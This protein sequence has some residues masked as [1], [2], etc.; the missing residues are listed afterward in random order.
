MST[1]KVGTIQD[2]TNST[3]ALTIDSSGR[4]ARPKVPAWLWTTGNAHGS[5][6]GGT[7]HD[8]LQWNDRITD[9]NGAGGNLIKGG[10]N[11]TLVIPV[12]GLYWVSYGGIKGSSSSAVGRMHMKRISGSG[13]NQFPQCRG[14]EN[15]PYAEMCV[16]FVCNAVAG[17]E[18]QCQTQSDG[19]WMGGAVTAASTGWNDPFWT[20]YLIG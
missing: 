10:T 13:D 2:H 17:D 3:T 9:T 8:P 4:V 16:A 7:A 20:G 5:H 15:S 14:E 11:H 6:N 18:W 19:M 12:T 1:L